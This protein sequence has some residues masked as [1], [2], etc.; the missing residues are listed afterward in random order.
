MIKTIKFSLLFL[1]MLV[2]AHKSEAKIWTVDNTPGSGADSTSVQGV[3]NVAS[4][5]DTIIIMPSITNYADISVTK[6]LYIYTR[7]HSS[8]NLDKD[9]RVYMSS[10][11]I[12]TGGSGSI[13]KGLS[14]SYFYI[15]G[16]N[17]NVQNC[18]AYVFL[19]IYSNNNVIL[20]CV[21]TSTVFTLSISDGAY[22]NIISN[23]YFVN[24]ITNGSYSGSSYGMLHGGN[25]SNL[26]KNCLFAEI[27]S[28]GSVSGNGFV[29]FK[30]SY[31]KVYNCLLWSNHPTRARF[32]TLN[33]GSIFKNNLT[34]SANSK[35]AA[36]PGTGNLN[37]TLPVFVG[38]YNSSNNLPFFRPE[39][40]MRLSSSSPGKN[41]GTDSTD[42]GLYGGGYNFSFEGNVPGVA[43][44]NDFEVMNPV[45]K[46]G[47]ILKVKVS[48]RKPD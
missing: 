17:V 28:G 9:R 19:Y 25:S 31:A 43:I 23:C 3:I 30:E 45:V 14:S 2:L 32:D 21:F 46:K 41:K 22:N 44:F 40:N 13:I 24:R 16:N 27:I 8:N 36:L 7:G 15:S 26:I 6:K 35:V 34:Y 18:L 1:C 42:V 38:G 11:N 48:A 12:A 39:N 20:G 33:Y 5:N 37:D 47:G 10:I 4:A 29:F